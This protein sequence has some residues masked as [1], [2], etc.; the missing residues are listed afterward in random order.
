VRQVLVECRARGHA[1]LLQLEDHQRQAVDEADRGKSE[2]RN[3]NSEVQSVRH[4]K[5]DIRH[6]TAGDAELADQQE[7]IVRRMLPLHR[8]QPLRLLPAAFDSLAASTGERAGVRS[9]IAFWHGH[10]DALPEQLARRARR[11]ALARVR[12]AATQRAKAER[13]AGRSNHFSSTVNRVKLAL[14]CAAISSEISS[15]FSG[16][17]VRMDSLEQENAGQVHVSFQFFILR[18]GRVLPVPS[19]SP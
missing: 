1:G 15:S 6:S 13:H 8:A 7:I 12:R 4:W 18:I 5:F 16:M 11:L 2:V 10:L 14:P 19:Q 17:L 9:R 3:A